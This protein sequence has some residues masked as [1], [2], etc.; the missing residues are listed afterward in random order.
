MLP[1]NLLRA[2]ISLGQIRPIYAPLDAS[3]LNLA[4]RMIKTFSKGIGSRKGELREKLKIFEDEV[5]DYRLVRGLSILLERRCVFSSDSC[6]DPKEARRL[7][8]EEASK[9][10]ISSMEDREGAIRSVSLK[11]G[12]DAGTLE[13]TLY[14]DIEEELLLK[15]FT[16][17]KPDALIKYYN[18]SLTQTLLFKSLSMEFKASGNWKEVFKAMGMLGLMYSVE[19]DDGGY[20]VSVDGPLSLLKMTE[21]YGTSLAKLLPQ[22][23]ASESWNV[24]ADILGRNKRR[25]YKFMLESSE[26][27]GIIEDIAHADLIDQGL[28]DSMIEERFARKFKTHDSGWLLKREPEPILAGRHVLIP[29]FSFERHGVKVYLEIVG[30]WTKEYIEKKISKLRSIMN[31]DM[32]IA[33]NE[34]LACSK[35][36]KIKGLIVYYKKDVPIKPIFDYLKKIEEAI[37]KEE[38]K[39]IGVEKI[40]LN[41]DI[42][43]LESLARKYS[44]TLK[45]MRTMLKCVDFEGYKK[46]GDYYLFNSKLLEIE[47]RLRNSEKL[48]EAIA[49]METYGI[50]NPYSILEALGYTIIWKGL[51]LEKSKIKKSGD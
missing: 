26:V 51:D 25:I 13:K 19:H 17:L 21:R 33:V 11:L 45:S 5:F 47:Q 31:T 9:V 27:E 44:I 2:R 8:F 41:G 7:V 20:K 37:I 18:L 12:I 36:K 30:F 6:I 16:L 14:S 4:E 46:I 40:R 15:D 23:I 35:F 49:T 22:I 3:T 29:D 39:T 32:I 48:S 1:Y 38:A 43:S 42:I 34:N 10:K 28:Y 24:K 50:K